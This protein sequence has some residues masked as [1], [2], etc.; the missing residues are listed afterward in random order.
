MLIISEKCP[1]CKDG[2]TIC[3]D[4]READG[5]VKEEALA[6]YY[7]EMCEYCEP[8]PKPLQERLDRWQ[9]EDREAIISAHIEA[10]GR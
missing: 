2:F 4:C 9:R 5:I 3:D 8:T 10:N 1:R 6:V 7:A